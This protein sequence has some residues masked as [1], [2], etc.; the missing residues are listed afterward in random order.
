[1]KHIFNYQVK[2]MNEN[3]EN[4]DLLSIS[5]MFNSMHSKINKEIN[6]IINSK[7]ILFNFNLISEKP[8]HV[9]SGQY[10]WPAAYFLSLYLITNW[11]NIKSNLI[12]ELGAGIG[13]CGIVSSYLERNSSDINQHNSNNNA[14]NNNNNNNNDNI[15]NRSKVILTDYDPGCI[16]LLTNNIIK[17]NCENNCQVEYLKWGDSISHLPINNEYEKILLL[18]S[19][20]LYCLDVVEPLFHTVSQLLNS[21]TSKN[22]LFLLASSFDVGE[23]RS[24]NHLNIFFKINL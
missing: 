12:I 15:N 14:D 22:G 7:E 17:N 10:L 6:F 11:N 4:D 9:Q 1:M 21:I 3:D 8:G 13:M 19:D 24:S 2:E 23:V 20:L 18:G 5:F 16:Q